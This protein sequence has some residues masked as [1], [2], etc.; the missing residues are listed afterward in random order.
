MAHVHFMCV[1][2]LCL[3]SCISDH[4]PTPSESTNI[5]LVSQTFLL[6]NVPSPLFYNPSLYQM[7]SALST[8]YICI[9]FEHVLSECV[10]IICFLRTDIHFNV[11]V[12]TNS[13]HNSPYILLVTPVHL[14]IYVV[15]I[16]IHVISH[17]HIHQIH[18]M[19]QQCNA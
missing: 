3:A 16:H 7:P 13:M 12:C 18:M 15:Y 14:H 10:L 6:H 9:C 17:I 11:L 5:L 4:L 1:V 8:L 2:D 19:C